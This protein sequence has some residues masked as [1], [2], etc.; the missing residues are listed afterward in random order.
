LNTAVSGTAVKDEDDVSSNS[1]TAVATQQSIKAFV[2][3][4]IAAQD[5]DIAPDSSTAQS[6]VLPSEVLII[7]GG[8]GIATSA[9]RNTV[10]F[11]ID[12]VVR[13][14]T[15][16]TLSNKHFTSDGKQAMAGVRL[17]TVMG[18]LGRDESPSARPTAF[19]HASP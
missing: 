18:Q 3:N 2:T 7:S 5:L 16:Q 11:K 10:T 8:S 15:T 19:P 17:C 14:A 4:L 12:S 9:T 1:A 13:L 6:I